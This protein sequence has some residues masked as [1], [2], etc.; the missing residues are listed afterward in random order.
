MSD[1]NEVF[2]KLRDDFKAALDRETQIR[3]NYEQGL[4]PQLERDLQAARKDVEA[5]AAERDYLQKW[6]SR[7]ETAWVLIERSHVLVSEALDSAPAAVTPAAPEV[8]DG[9]PPSWR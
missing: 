5:L 6:K 3:V 7:A 4:I 8:D 2:D 9:L 1:T